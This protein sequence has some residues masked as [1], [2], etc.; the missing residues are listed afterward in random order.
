MGYSIFFALAIL[1]LAIYVNRD[2]F[3]SFN[4]DGAIYKLNRWRRNMLNKLWVNY[5]TN[6]NTMSNTYNGR[7]SDLYNDLMKTN[8]EKG[9]FIDSVKKYKNSV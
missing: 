5:N 7:S 2:Y 1:L 4:I 9:R 3:K 6:K 8:V